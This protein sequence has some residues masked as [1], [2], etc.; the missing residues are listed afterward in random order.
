[1]TVK[2]NLD[3]VETLENY[4]S[5]LYS[6]D[7]K[8][9]PVDIFTFISDP[10]Y[11][12][13]MTN[14]GNSIF[15]VWK[16]ELH[17]IMRENGKFLVVLTGAIGCL[18]EDVK[19]SLLD[20]REL[21]IPEIIKERE[22]GKK[23]WVYSYDLETNSV[24]P[25]E[26]VDAMLSGKNT[27]TVKVTLDNGESISCTPNHPFLLSS[28]KYVHAEDLK[29]GDSLMPLYRGKNH[30]GYEVCGA[31]KGKWKPT[32]HMVSNNFNGK[33]PKGHCIHHK[34]YNKTNNN[35]DNLEVIKKEDHLHIHAVVHNFWKEDVEKHKEISK[36]GLDS[37]WN[38]VDSLEYKR[39][40]SELTTKRNLSGL[41][42]KA[43]NSLYYGVNSE[44]HREQRRLLFIERNKTEL[45]YKKA[46]DIRWSKEGAKEEYSK[47]MKHYWATHLPVKCYQTKQCLNCGEDIRVLCNPRPNNKKDKVIKFCSGSCASKYRGKIRRGEISINHK[48]VSV[49]ECVNQDVYDLSIDKYNNFALTSGVFV[50][51]TGK[52]RTGILGMLYTVYRILCLKDPYNYFNLAPGKKFQVAFF[53]LTKSLSNSSSYQIFQNYMVKSPWFLERGG[54]RGTQDKWLDL[55]LFE[56]KLCSPYTQGFGSLGGDVIAAMMDECDSPTETKVRKL[57]LIEAYNNTVIRFK[58]RFVDTVTNETLGKF[59]LV[60]S[61]QEEASF[62]EA[63]VSERK[64]YKDTYVVDMPIWEVKG[65]TQFKGEKFPVMV[66]NVYTPSKI[67]NGDAEIKEAIAGGYTVINVPEE[68]RLDFQRDINRSLRDLAGVSVTGQRKSKLIP[69]QET[70]NQCYDATKL[71]PV[72][73]TTIILG[74]K[75]DNTRIIHLLDLSK[76]RIPKNVPRFI[77][78]DIAFSGDGDSY[79][80]AMSCTKGFVNQDVMRESGEY[81]TRQVPLIETDFVFRVRA[82]PG[83]KVP[84]FKIREFIFDLRTYGFNIKKCTFDLALASEDTKQL[85]TRRGIVCE[86][87]SLD[88]KPEYYR[89]FRD[90]V[91]EQRWVCHKNNLLNFELINLEDDLDA[92][93]IDHPDKVKDVVFL[94]DGGIK[95]VVLTGSKDL[96]DATV[97]S[98]VSALSCS[99]IPLDINKAREIMRRSG[100][101]T[102]KETKE[103]LWWVDDP[104]AKVEEIVEVGKKTINQTVVKDIFNRLK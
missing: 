5:V 26:V 66:G 68:Y 51:N 9:R 3:I 4:L 61:K 94:Q 104:N 48:V 100:A 85:L 24:V 99:E 80:I 101:T 64:E 31:F 37:R 25:G 35:P 36:K 21:T 88:K 2:N 71:D 57:R 47:K 18:G 29:E 22:E 89:Q 97:G 62:L 67:L 20:G 27:K 15:K 38:G 102:L 45:L 1:M 75:D 41:A 12:G 23:H 11:L 28:G 87:L 82:K 52:S 16:K 40:M 56:W 74:L 73:K 39:E 49:E 14:N 17:Q 44:H 72:K 96:S 50:H 78:G 81:E 42:K 43:S 46:Q 77:H 95:D 55:P 59:F 65:D 91:S 10:Y 84:L 13:S 98:V 69:S 92:N 34:D 90:L 79:G 8:E 58:S 33:T 19:V 32:Y 53:N 70:L 83:D 76:I 54:I 103:Q 63:F 6:V 7:F 60:S 93:K 30:R 86:Y